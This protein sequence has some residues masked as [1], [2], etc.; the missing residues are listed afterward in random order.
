VWVELPG[1]RLAV[2]VCYFSPA[3]SRVYAQGFLQGNPV[4][5]LLDAVAAYHD[6]GW[7]V[8]CL[9][10]FNVRIG[11][12]ADDVAAREGVRHLP[13]ADVWAAPPDDCVILARMVYAMYARRE[14]L[15]RV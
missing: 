6:R 13:G 9:G 7:R 10:D 3:A 15:L 2:A 8:S 4:R 12:M 1:S 5:V 14:E 11:A